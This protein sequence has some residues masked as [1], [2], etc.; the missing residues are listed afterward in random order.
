MGLGH[1]LVIVSSVHDQ[2]Q[3]KVI[4]MD[5]MPRA[6]LF[7]GML[8]SALLGQFILCCCYSQHKTLGCWREPHKNP[9]FSSYADINIL[10]TNPV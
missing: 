2:S 1:N 10:Y 5:T 3:E 6:V 7:R 8:N 9:E 4:Q